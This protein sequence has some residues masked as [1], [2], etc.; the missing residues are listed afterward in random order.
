MTVTWPC[1]LN[2]AEVGVVAAF[3]RETKEAARQRLAA[4]RPAEQH[5]AYT[6]A[7]VCNEMGM[8]PK[9]AASSD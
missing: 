8:V 7:W 3:F 9:E 1:W 2:D 5:E 4:M 6:I